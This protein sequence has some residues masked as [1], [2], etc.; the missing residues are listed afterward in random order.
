MPSTQAPQAIRL[1]GAF[2]FLA[3]GHSHQR[4]L[5]RTSQQWSFRGCM[6]RPGPDTIF[7]LAFTQETDMSDCIVRPHPRAEPMDDPMLCRYLLPP[8]EPSP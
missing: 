2:S 5:A 1:R 6:E 8:P 7:V 4:K 3:L